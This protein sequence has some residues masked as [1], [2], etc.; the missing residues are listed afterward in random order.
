LVLPLFLAGLALTH[1]LKFSIPAFMVLYLVAGSGLALVHFPLLARGVPWMIVAAGLACFSYLA[2]I[3]HEHYDGADFWRGKVGR[4]AYL[5]APKRISPYQEAARWIARELPE[6]ARLLVVGGS[7]GLYLERPFVNQSVFD[8]QALSRIVR[9]ASDARGV[10]EGLRR[11]GV[12][13]LLVLVPEG[14]NVI[15]YRHYDLGPQEWARLDEAIQTGTDLVYLKDLQGIYRLRAPSPRKGEAIPD[16]VLFLSEPAANFI[17]AG[18]NGRWEEAERELTKV[19]RL[20]P[21]SGDWK[22]QARIFREA[23]QG[24]PPR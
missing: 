9:S 21:F 14:L 16:L 11:M 10:L 7:R 3:H 24:S 19:L 8:E 12:D 18:Q 23:R 15:G 5:Q 20:Y 17:L 4:D 6:D 22:R 13:H 1:I 2:A